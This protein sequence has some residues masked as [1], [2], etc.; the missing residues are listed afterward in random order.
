MEN[1]ERVSPGQVPQV[2]QGSLSGSR[3]TT[4]GRAL[5]VPRLSAAYGPSFSAA[6]R[7]AGEEEEGAFSADEITAFV[8]RVVANDEDA[9]AA[10][11]RTLVDRGVAVETIYLDLVGPTARRLGE[12]WTDDACD[13]VDVTIA[14]GRLQRVVREMSHL[15]VGH[16]ARAGAGRVLLSC[17]PGEQHTLGLF[18]VSEFFVRDGWE[19]S[20]AAPIA[21]CP[22]DTLV[23]DEWFDVVGFSVACNS[24]LGYL[25]REIPR[26]RR[27]SRNPRVAM[28]V[29]GR[30]FNDYPAMVGR[31]R[32]DASASDARGAPL[33]ARRLI[34]GGTP[35]PA[36]V[37]GDTPR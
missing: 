3:A 32:A 16:G 15:F 4:N 23:R 27:V 21:A 29:G 8:D 6:G 5:A 11:V 30:V 35:I 2:P 10:H 28:M 13:F 31:V 19:V 25:A 36:A 18:M 7:P 34:A 1:H 9:A 22:I 20:L 14:L 24:R 12:L 17:I 26:L 33:L 37:A